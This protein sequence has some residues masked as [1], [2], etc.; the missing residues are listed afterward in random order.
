MI[1]GLSDISDNSWLPGKFPRGQMTPWPPGLCAPDGVVINAA[2]AF[3]LLPVI[4]FV[5]SQWRS[6]TVGRPVRVW[7]LPPSTQQLG[8]AILILSVGLGSNRA[9]HS[10]KICSWNGAF[11]ARLSGNN[12]QHL[13]NYCNLSLY[14]FVY[15]KQCWYKHV[16]T[17]KC[18]AKNC[19]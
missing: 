14:N 8:T 19:K 2:N 7:K 3:S 10:K 18:H 15:K 1:I 13:I 5:S 4:L 11:F 16:M 12:M 9:S 6:V 17:E